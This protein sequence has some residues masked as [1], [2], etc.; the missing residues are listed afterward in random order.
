MQ[1]IEICLNNML[2]ITLE[3]KFMT[4]LRVFFIFQGNGPSAI[5][6][7]YM[8]AGNWPYYNG[9]PHPVEFLQYRLQENKQYSLL[10]Q[11]NSFLFVE[12]YMRT[13]TYITSSAS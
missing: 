6:L 12:Y 4:S 10:E 11:V 8:L 3:L 1:A 2:K 13:K 9:L 7:S 5:T